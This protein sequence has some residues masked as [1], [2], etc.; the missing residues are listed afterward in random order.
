MKIQKLLLNG[1]AVGK[2]AVA[3]NFFLRLRGM[4]GRNFDNFDAMIFIPCN[5][6]HTFFMRY[7]IDVI[8]L[9]RERY[10]TAFFECVPKGHVLPV[11]MKTEMVIEMPA[12]NICKYGI[13]YRDCLRAVCVS[14]LQYNCK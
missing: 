6:V 14:N 11:K 3:D 8:Y 10:V 5:G 13:K 7:A 4:I 2:T 9:N 12:G 1:K